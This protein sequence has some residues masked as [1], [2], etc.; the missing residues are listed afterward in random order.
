MTIT[1]KQLLEIEGALA[2][3]SSQETEAWYQIGRNIQRIKP[4]IERFGESRKEII[5]RLSEK[6]KNGNP[7]VD[8]NNISFGDNAE[9]FIEKWTELM[10]ESIEVDFYTFPFDKFGS[11]KLD[12][13]KVQP[14]MDIIVD[15]E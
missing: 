6:D 10:E 2:Y 11:A 5:D 13:I 4:L 3:V 12:A 15:G 8:G 14:L 7:K 9:E 1:N